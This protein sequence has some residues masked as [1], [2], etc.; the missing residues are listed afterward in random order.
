MIRVDSYHPVIGLARS[1]NRNAL[2]TN[3]LLGNTSRVRPK[4][5]LPVSTHSNR[6]WSEFYQNCWESSMGILD[7]AGLEA[8]LQILFQG[9][10]A[11]DDPAWYALRNVVFAGACRSLLLKSNV[12]SYET[13]QSRANRYF[14]N[15]LSVL[16]DILLSPSS[17]TAIRALVLMVRTLIRFI[18]AKANL[19]LTSDM[20]C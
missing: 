4:A 2:L 16:T 1:P 11:T 3:Q 5:L 7:R 20:L 6:Q 14:E 18:S 9:D 8:H 12:V 15:A 17:L 10:D 13:A 19:V